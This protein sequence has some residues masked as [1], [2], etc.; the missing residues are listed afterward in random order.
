M[1]KITKNLLEVTQFLLDRGLPELNFTLGER[2][3]I[4]Q[5]SYSVRALNIDCPPIFIS[6]LPKSGSIYILST[7]RSTLNLDLQNYTSGEFPYS[8]INYKNIKKWA[9]PGYINLEHISADPINLRLINFYCDRMVIHT[10][11]PRQAV[12]SWVHFL[13]KMYENEKESLFARMSLQVPKDYFEWEFPERLDWYLKH[14]FQPW[15]EWIQKW[16]D[17]EEDPN[18]KTKI[19]FTSH[20]E[21]AENPKEL[22]LKISRFYDLPDHHFMNMQ[23]PKKKEGQLHFRKGLVNEWLEVFTEEQKELTSNFISD[24]LKSRF[25][26]L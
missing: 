11:D 6:T 7:I 19:L 14:N 22:F 2:P 18:F 4:F 20:Q 26:W 12:L 25:G 24:D 1:E 5:C 15:V 23:L 8:Y 9:N 21:L 10:R 13:P 17:A 16:V 3:N